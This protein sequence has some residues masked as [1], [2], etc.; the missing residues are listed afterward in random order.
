MLERRS[1]LV[2]MGTYESDGIRAWESPDFSIHHMWFGSNAQD[3]VRDFGAMMGL[4][5]KI[6]QVGRPKIAKMKEDEIYC[7]KVAP[8]QYWMIMKFGTKGPKVN[9]LTGSTAASTTSLHSSRCRIHVEGD[10]IRD[11]LAKCAAVDFHPQVFKPDHFV[12]TGV[13]HVPVLIHCTAADQF[14]VYVMRTFA[15][16]LWEI[17]V[18]ATGGSTTLSSG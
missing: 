12:M 4:P 14:H 18:D 15:L 7:F 11:V 10:R 13:H 5:D 16:S 9:G 17:L 3:I 8:D 6:G 2:D 1:V